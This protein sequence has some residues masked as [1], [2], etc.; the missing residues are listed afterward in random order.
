LFF[1]LLGTKY[2][3]G[4]LNP[5]ASQI[6]HILTW[7]S[8]YFSEF[9]F[10]ECDHGSHVEAS[11]DIYGLQYTSCKDTA[12]NAYSHYSW[13]QNCNILHRM[14]REGSG[15]W[16]KILS[17]ERKANEL[18]G[19]LIQDKLNHVATA[20]NEWGHTAR[21]CIANLSRSSSSRLSIS[22]N[23]L[24]SRAIL[25]GASCCWPRLLLRPGISNSLSTITTDYSL[26]KDGE[27]YISF[28][29]SGL[30][31]ALSDEYCSLRISEVVHGNHLMDRIH[32]TFNAEEY[33]KGYLCSQY[34]ALNYA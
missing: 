3:L 22:M 8:A 24:K 27:L 16:Q 21:I 7:M 9:F 14:A 34:R 10:I 1:L 29:N 12:Q 15:C 32:F 20:W 30:R 23:S 31:M 6:I 13:V 2:F 5:R 4:I 33:S 17:R 26:S 28:L 18:Y 11:H 25:N 19:T